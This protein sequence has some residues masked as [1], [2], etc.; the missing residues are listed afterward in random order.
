MED[1]F[2]SFSRPWMMIW[3]LNCISNSEDKIWGGGVRVLVMFRQEFSKT[4][5]LIQGP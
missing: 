2:K 1:I 3:D 4:L 5:C